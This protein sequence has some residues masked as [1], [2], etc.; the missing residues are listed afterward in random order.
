[1]L[2]NDIA[3]MQNNPNFSI[4]ASNTIYIIFM[5]IGIVG[6]FTVP[7]VANWIISAGSM[8]AYNRNLTATASGAG[9]ITGA[10]VGSAT[11]NIT[12]RLINHSKKIK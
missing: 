12:G 10:V 7:S 1:M 6:F 8:N 4:D 9:G 5:I 3:E 11:G 2:Q